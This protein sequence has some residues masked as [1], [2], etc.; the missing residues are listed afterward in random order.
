MK[1]TF[2][3]TIVAIFF[4]SYVFAAEIYESNLIGK[5]VLTAV[6]HSL[7]SDPE[8]WRYSPQSWEFKSHGVMI[9]TSGNT[10]RKMKYMIEDKNIKIDSLG[11]ITIYKVESYQYDQMIWLNTTMNNYYHL[12]RSN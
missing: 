10:S 8:P 12:K 1:K 11:F 3:T 4:C 7:S 5:W 6:S 2:I 9:Y